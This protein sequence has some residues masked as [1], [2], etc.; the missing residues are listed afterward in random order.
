MTILS[1]LLLICGLMAQ[2]LYVGTYNIRYNNPDDTTEGNGWERRYPHLCDFINFEEPAIFGTQEVLADQLRDLRKGL[3]GYGYLG[4][5]RD[6]GKEAGEYAAI[7]YK[8]NRLEVL[9][10][11][12][13]WLSETPEKPSLGWDAACV[14]ICTCGKFMDRTTGKVFFFFNT[15]MD[16]EG[17]V[18]RRE[19]PP[20]HQPHSRVGKRPTH[21][22][23]GRLQRG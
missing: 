16:H 22:S 2:P 11:G 14:R 5:G 4:V 20:D 13:F 10:S 9:E 6:D 1:G 8:T 23:H 21:Y 17:I 19:S 12:N 15:H 7:F 18:A 3:D